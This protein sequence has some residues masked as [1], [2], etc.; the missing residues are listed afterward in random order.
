MSRTGLGVFG[1]VDG[2]D[3][4]TRLAVAR[5]LLA[6]P[7][8]LD[9]GHQVIRSRSNYLMPSSESCFAGRLT[10]YWQVHWCFLGKPFILCLLFSTLLLT[11]FSS[12]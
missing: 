3:L 11:V 5:G 6:L 7:Q 4:G 12:L 2:I 8:D 9:L 1:G 10:R